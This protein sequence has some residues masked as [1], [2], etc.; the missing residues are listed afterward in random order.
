MS[1]AGK[2]KRHEWVHP[3]FEMPIAGESYYLSE[4][5]A[6]IWCRKLKAMPELTKNLRTLAKT[7]KGMR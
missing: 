4:I 5:K 6:C 2:R 1:C 3:L 7:L